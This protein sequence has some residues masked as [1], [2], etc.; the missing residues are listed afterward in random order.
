MLLGIELITLAAEFL[1]QKVIIVRGISHPLLFPNKTRAW[2]RG[3]DFFD[4]I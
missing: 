1:R 3:H 2:S 4:S